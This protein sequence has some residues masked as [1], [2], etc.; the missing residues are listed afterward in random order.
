MREELIGYLLEALD[1]GER[2]RV[3]A[4]LSDPQTGPALR[5]D[6]GF[7]RRALSPLA[8]DVDD[9]RPPPGLARR[10]L[11]HVE[12]Y[13][14]VASHGDP[15]SDR[16]PRSGRHAE[17]YRESTAA[18]RHRGPLPQPR[19][20]SPESSPRKVRSPRVWIDRAILAAT[21]IAASVLFVPL[22]LDGIGQS[23]AL[24]TERNLQQIGNALVGY[25]EEH[26]RLPMPPG[27]GALSRAGLY[28]PTLVSEHRLRADDGTFLVPGS[29][30]ARRGYVIP[31]LDEVRRVEASGDAQAFDSMIRSMGG[32]FGYTLGHRDA[33]GVLQ[34]YRN[35]GR[36]HHPI[37]ADAPDDGGHWSDNH[38]KRLHHLLF[39][40][41][42]VERIGPHAVHLDDHL[43]RNH[44]GEVGAG[45]DPED[46][47]I[48]DS[49]HQP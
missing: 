11:R 39:E 22:V 20:F 47:V 18:T 5:R 48:G 7:L 13:P 3:D 10:T 1:E 44:R 42:R 21:A 26:R 8:E 30:L 4:A 31:S 6:L 41:G 15:Q 25:A 16:D 45:V 14:R 12:S 40:D 23:R 37:M 43:Y 33:G 28:A 34:P 17:R 46:A 49:H 24:R 19:I 9:E 27:S 29:A 2:R 32:D 36:S 38:P 35:L